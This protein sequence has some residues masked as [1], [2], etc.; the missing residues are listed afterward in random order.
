MLQE[1]ASL[2][3]LPAAEEG[4][5]SIGLAHFPGFLLAAVLITAAPGPDNLMVLSLGM[6]K[7]RRQG[8]V[9]GLGCALGCLCHTA[10]AAAG[11]SALIAASPTAFT[12][13]RM[14]GGAYLLWL[15]VQAL[16][17]AGRAG[18]GRSAQGL[19]S[20]LTQLFFKGVLANAV[21]PKV[22]LF[23][24]SFLPQFVDAPRGQ[25][26]L[27]MALLGL[28]FTAQAALLFGLLGL[29]AG[30]VGQW[31]QRRPGASAWLDR[32]AGTVFVVLG[33]RLVVSD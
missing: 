23:F 14:A 3:G 11:V 16:R 22:V 4:G 17:S 15:G 25:V 5:M 7:G 8:M 29:S 21:N 20:S 24:L 2:Q 10:L 18:P 33:L 31:L 6:S 12:A 27:Q 30:A 13:L 26:G 1:P 28:A 9:F 32:L 19:E